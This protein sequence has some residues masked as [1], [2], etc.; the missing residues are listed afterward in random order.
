[1]EHTVRKTIN[2]G[3]SN[4]RPQHVYIRMTESDRNA[5][6]QVMGGFKHFVG[7]QA[8]GAEIFAK[9]GIPAMKAALKEL[10]EKTKNKGGGD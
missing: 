2:H 8:T 6:N 10:I 9:Y 1:M 4:R 3:R 5:Y 7:P